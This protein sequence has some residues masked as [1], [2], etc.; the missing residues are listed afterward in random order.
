MTTYFCP[1]CGKGLRYEDRESGYCP[2]CGKPL[3]ATLALSERVRPEGPR[4]AAE[5]EPPRRS[6]VTEMR[7]VSRQTMRFDLLGWG[8]VR[9]GLALTLVGGI[10]AC[11]GLA[12]ILLLVLSDTSATMSRGNSALDAVARELLL[13]LTL[14]G[15]SMHLCGIFMGSAA[16]ADS[17]SKGAAIACCAALSLTLLLVL[18]NRLVMMEQRHSF[19]PMSGR[20]VRPSTAFGEGEQKA[21]EYAQLFMS[22]IAGVCYCLFL[23]GVARFFKRDGLA[24][25]ILA[26]LL[27][28]LVYGI[29]VTVYRLS[30]EIITEPM[31]WV[32]LGSMVALL[33]WFF[34]LVGLVR[35]AI[36]RG[37]LRAS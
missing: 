22:L 23:R 29:G 8:T 16:P 12:I 9:A 33:V 3:P 21:L 37:L 32:L 15:A 2:G 6:A 19:D 20:I 18:V 4:R 13:F 14:L 30:E 7:E 25:G 24:A 27:I 36:T 5:D 11:L 26:F 34:V 10:L 1:G 28:G 35:G 17:G 31:R